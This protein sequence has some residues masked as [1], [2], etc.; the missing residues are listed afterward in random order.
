MLWRRKYRLTR[1]CPHRP[2]CTACLVCAGLFL[3]LLAPVAD[4][5]LDLSSLWASSAAEKLPTVY[6][7]SQTWSSPPLP[8][9]V[10]AVR[11]PRNCTEA[12]A[13]GLQNI[14]RGSPYYAPHLDR[15]NDGL[16]C[17]PWHGR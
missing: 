13:W 8:Q 3:V 15:D 10:R 17:E 12:R 2:R 5:G 16:G 14:P 9:A 7:P 11:P 6:T 1:W 4:T